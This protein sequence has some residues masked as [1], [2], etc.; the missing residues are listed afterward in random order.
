MPCACVSV[1]PRE[2]A[3][4]AELEACVRATSWPDRALEWHDAAE[5]RLSS[6]V[7]GDAYVEHSASCSDE[8]LP[9]WTFVDQHTEDPAG[10]ISEQTPVSYTHLRAH[11]TLR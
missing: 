6:F 1:A 2:G 7:S 9:S 8:P 5:R 11:E 3:S 10:C 4:L